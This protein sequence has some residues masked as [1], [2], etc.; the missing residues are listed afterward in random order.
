MDLL[1]DSENPLAVYRGPKGPSRWFTAIEQAKYKAKAVADATV[2]RLLGQDARTRIDSLTS[3]QDGPDPFGFDPNVARYA[4][5]AAKA[6]YKNYFRTEVFGIENVPAGRV[7]LISNHSGQIPLDGMAIGAALLLEAPRPR[8][9]RS[10]VEK[11]T[12]TLP[13]IAELFPRCGQI[14]GVPENCIRLLE[15]DEAVLVF[16]EGA[17][18][19]S[20]TFD[21]RYKLTE[22]GLG[23]MRMA[24]AAKAPIVPVAVIGAEEQYVSVANL[25]RVGRLVGM[26]ALPI[27]PQLLLPGGF[28]PLP[29]KYRLHFGPP[30]Q[31]D[32]EPDDEDAVID[33]KV[34][35]VRGTIQSMINRGLK[36]RRSIFR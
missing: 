13:F 11:W 21:Q 15:M 22:F 33:E 26:P 24:L 12:A 6:I 18:G 17:R 14:V 23:F 31:F 25:E 2:N 34:Q 28:L 9:V 10:M 8:F 29:T 3:A 5:L 30:L 32:G 27:L 36:E 19:I 35:H 1:N 20:K 4:V 16:P 7:L